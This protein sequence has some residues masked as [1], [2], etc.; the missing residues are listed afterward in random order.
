[1]RTIVSA[2]ISAIKGQY[3]TVN[4]PRGRIISVRPKSSDT[5]VI[6]ILAEHY[7]PEPEYSKRSFRFYFDGEHIDFTEIYTDISTYVAESYFQP[8]CS[9][10]LF[11]R[12]YS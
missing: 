6:S 7:T 9:I 11:E 3:T 5:F 8:G 12:W 2:E 1:M 10:H 4:A